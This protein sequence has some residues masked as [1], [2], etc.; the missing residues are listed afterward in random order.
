MST[1]SVP[2]EASIRWRI[3]A[4]LPWLPS[5]DW[6]TAPTLP[7]PVPDCSTVA[8][9]SVPVWS[10][11]ALLPPPAPLCRTRAVRPVE[12][13]PSWP[14]WALL[15]PPEPDWSMSALPPEP[16]WPTEATSPSPAV[17]VSACRTLTPWLRPAWVMLASCWPPGPLW[18]TLA[19]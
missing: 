4:A 9:W 18:W 16:F 7:P 17:L 15:P 10:M 19:R 2:V 13:A 11:S 6:S 12:F 1:L 8:A 3:V 5:V 14:I